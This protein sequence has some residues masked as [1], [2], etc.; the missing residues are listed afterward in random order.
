MDQNKIQICREYHIQPS[1]IDRLKFYEY[2][3]Y[4]DI[5]LGI[6]KKEEE[7]RKKDEKNNK[8]PSLNSLT[9]SVNQHMP[10]MS[11]PKFR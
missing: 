6:Q 3:E 9:R 2:E 7:Q 11:V 5:I 1:E 8:M 10:K 4:L